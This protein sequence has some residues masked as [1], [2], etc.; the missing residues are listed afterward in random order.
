MSLNDFK[1]GYK[2]GVENWR[3]A[4]LRITILPFVLV[5]IVDVTKAVLR[6]EFIDAGVSA[7]LW[8]LV[9]PLLWVWWIRKR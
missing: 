2:A 7:M 9:A 1:E 6:H 4:P 8:W 3:S 5:G